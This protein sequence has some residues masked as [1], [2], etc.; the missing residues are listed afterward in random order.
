MGDVWQGCKSDCVCFA[1]PITRSSQDDQ[2]DENCPY[3]I[4]DGEGGDMGTVTTSCENSDCRVCVLMNKLDRPTLVALGMKKNERLTAMMELAPSIAHQLNS[5]VIPED[6]R[7]ILV[8]AFCNLLSC[9]K[10]RLRNVANV[11]FLAMLCPRL[12]YLNLERGWGDV[13][14][15][16]SKM[17][18]AVGY[19]ADQRSQVAALIYLRRRSIPDTNNRW[20]W[21]LQTQG[22][23]EE[24][25]TREVFAGCFQDE[26]ADTPGEGGQ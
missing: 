17:A 1:E 3:C 11:G 8:T 6:R 20:H 19:H 16:L 18:T 5:G 7:Q 13:W 2:R 10:S 14:S 4:Q 21:F 26:Q 24:T 15:N 22:T 25:I 9:S 23:E 12:R